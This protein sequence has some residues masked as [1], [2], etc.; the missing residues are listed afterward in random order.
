MSLKDV[1][2]VAHQLPRH[3]GPYSGV[4][5][6]PDDGRNLDKLKLCAGRRCEEDTGAPAVAAAK[7]SL[8]SGITRSTGYSALIA[9]WL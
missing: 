4:K 6:F 3:E 1:L 5:F 9:V 8:L 7:S 2:I